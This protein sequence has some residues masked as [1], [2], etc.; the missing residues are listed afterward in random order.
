MDVLTKVEADRRWR[1]DVREVVRSRPGALASHRTAAALWGLDGSPPEV[2]EVLSEGSWRSS[3]APD[4]VTH[5]TTD[6]VGGDVSERDGVPCTS[7]VRTLVDLPAVLDRPAAARVLDA[8]ARADDTVLRRVARRH[9]EVAR[10]DRRGSAAL[11]ALLAERGALVAATDA[12]FET[13]AFRLIGGSD[14]PLPVARW[15]VT[16]AEG[17]CSVDLAWPELRVALECDSRA[18]RLSHAGLRWDQTRRWRLHRQG[19]RVVEV[20]LDEVVADGDLV[21]ARLADHLA[22]R[23]RKGLLL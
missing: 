13:Q 6:L 16:D 20:S 12:G 10:P 18:Q 15:Q 21:L 22:D 1:R 14:L 5:G 8:A 11:H 7:L 4:V 3:S 19:W 2:V 9:L 17:S 23:R